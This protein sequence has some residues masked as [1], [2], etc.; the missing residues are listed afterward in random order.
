MASW[1][2]VID[3]YIWIVYNVLE[4][5]LFKLILYKDKTMTKQTDVPTDNNEPEAPQC[6]GKYRGQ[7]IVHDG[8]TWEWQGNYWKRLL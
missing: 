6:I 1:P 5:P 8:A 4:L 7:Q 3:N 2:I